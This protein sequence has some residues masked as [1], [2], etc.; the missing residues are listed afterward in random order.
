MAFS[1]KHT[2]QSAIADGG[3]ATLVQPSNWNAEHTL[4]FSATDLLLGRSTAGAGVAEEIPCTA[5]ARTILDDADAA[6]IR[7]TLGLVIGTNVQAFDAELSA[8]A[9]LASAA[10]KLPYFTGSGTAALADFSAAARTVLDDATVA[11][12]VDTLGGASSSG[13]GG[14]ARVISPTFSTSII[15]PVVTITQGTIT[16]NAPQLDGSVTLNNAGVT[17]TA[18]KLNVIRS[19][20]LAASKLLDIQL[21]STS[22]FKIDT[23]NSGDTNTVSTFSGI[24]RVGTAIE[25]TGN[26]S[27]I[28]IKGNSPELDFGSSADL[29]LRRGAANILEQRNGTNAQAA[30]WENTYTSS[31]NREYATADW[32]T[33]ANLFRLM[34]VKGSGGGIARA[35]ALGTD[36]ID[37]ILIDAL[38][39][40]A[41]NGGQAALATTATDGY[42]RIP[43]CAGAPTGVPTAMTGCVALHYDTTNDKLWIYSGGAWKQPKTPAGAAIVTWQ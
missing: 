16:A 18:W 26:G 37:R 21:D 35:I 30:R 1:A 34:T 8:I 42:V 20:Q 31:T 9:G 12:M 24:L 32:Q 3:D 36:S 41:L 28:W 15:T 33:T 13:T 4:L 40:V 39:N 43:T 25:T 14:L 6:A 2:F 17:F 19:A 27:Y 5:F 22:V 11:A 23:I 10:D 29:I 7:T 38:G